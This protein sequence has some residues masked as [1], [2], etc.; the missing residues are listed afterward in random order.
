MTN[1]TRYNSNELI[2]KI[3]NVILE[4]INIKEQIKNDKDFNEV[5]MTEEVSMSK[6]KETEKTLKSQ[7]S[8]RNN[9]L[10]NEYKDYMDKNS[11]PNLLF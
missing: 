1:L 8:I 9:K 2:K 3:N 6:F 4:L 11:M 5:L 7:N 10:E